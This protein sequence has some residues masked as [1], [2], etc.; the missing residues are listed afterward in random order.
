MSQC[1]Q[2]RIRACTALLVGFPLLIGTAE[3]QQSGTTSKPPFDP[4]RYQR[5]EECLAL[6]ARLVDSVLRMSVRWDTLPIALSERREPFP[7]VITDP[8]GRCGAK[9]KASAVPLK[10]FLLME[11]LFLATDRFA[12][13]W[14]LLDRR[15]AA[16][17]VGNSGATERAAVLDSLFKKFFT[18]AKPPRLSDADSVLNLLN[19]LPEGTEGWFVRL[20]RASVFYGWAKDYGDTIRAKRLAEQVLAIGRSLTAQERSTEL[21]VKMGF[22]WI[23]GVERD[24]GENMRL[25]LFRAGR[26]DEVVDSLKA[27]WGRAGDGMIPWTWPVGRMAPTLN[28]NWFNAQGKQLPS[29]INRPTVGRVSLVAFYDIS[30]CLRFVGYCYSTQATLRRLRHRFPALEINIVAEQPQ[31]WVSALVKDTPESEG[32]MWGQWIS[33]FHKL[34]DAVVVESPGFVRV[35]GI[36]QRAIMNPGTNGAAYRGDMPYQGMMEAETFLIDKTGRIVEWYNVGITRLDEAMASAQI[37]ALLATPSSG[38]EQK[39]GTT[40]QPI[41]S[42]KS[43]H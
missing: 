28:G 19:Q 20:E 17:P 5:I 37:E 24:L 21:F 40:A 34:A 14:T 36:D 3:A 43:Q 42:P 7:V 6:K 11:E 29:P 31:A 4:A 23:F 30:A 32:A 2:H 39:T 41:T 27:Q 33:G 38:T 22:G 12:D 26:I 18:A 15:L 25:G 16:I 1:V 9:F 13:V 35:P 8:V 10:D